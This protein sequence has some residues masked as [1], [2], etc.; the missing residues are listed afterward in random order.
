MGVCKPIRRRGRQTKRIIAF[1]FVLCFI[2]FSL[3]FVFFIA[4]HAGHGCVNKMGNTCLHI[5]AAQKVFHQIETAGHY[6]CL[7]LVCLLAAIAFLKR[8]LMGYDTL[9]LVDVK[10]RMNN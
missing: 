1:A 4:A 6:I 8:I 3:L 2:A 9:V 10:I 7:A 5:Q